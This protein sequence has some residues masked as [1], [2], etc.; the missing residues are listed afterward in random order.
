MAEAKEEEEYYRF[1]AE[2]HCSRSDLF[3][4]VGALLHLSRLVRM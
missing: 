4:P 3:A 1:V 2:R